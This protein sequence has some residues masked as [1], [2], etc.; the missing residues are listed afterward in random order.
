MLRELDGKTEGQ[1]H[2][3]SIVS[4]LLKKIGF[5]Y[6]TYGYDRFKDYILDLEARNL[7][8]TK[9]NGLTHSVALLKNTN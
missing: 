4:A 8:E 2:L 1:F 3:F 9:A 6:Q 5:N 7:V